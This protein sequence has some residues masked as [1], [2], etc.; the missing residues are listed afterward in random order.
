MLEHGVLG[1]HIACSILHA[2]DLVDLTVGCGV[3][4]LGIRCTRRGNRLLH[5]SFIAAIPAGACRKGQRH[6]T[7]RAV[8][9]V[10][11][12]GDLLGRL[13][14]NHHIV[15]PAA[16]RKG[17]KGAAGHKLHAQLT[18]SIRTAVHADLH[19]AIAGA[20]G[21]GLDLRLHVCAD[22]GGI[23]HGRHLQT[24]AQTDIAAALIHAAGIHSPCG[25]AQQRHCTGGS[26]QQTRDSAHLHKAFSFRRGH[27]SGAAILFQF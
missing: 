2:V 12:I 25:R 24:I 17:I 5:R 9:V 14:R 19:H 4:C 10:H 7:V 16:L 20:A 1:R 11:G 26:E 15:R 22:L 18:F 21:R 13:E 6:G 27:R 23:L 8:L 3:I